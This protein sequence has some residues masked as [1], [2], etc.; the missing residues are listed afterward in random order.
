M[1]KSIFS[2]GFIILSTFILCG[3]SQAT[4]IQE[5]S[6]E[7]QKILNSQNKDELSKLFSKEL[8]EDLRIKYTKFSNNLS[9]LKWIIKP[10]KN[11]SDNRQSIEVIVKGNKKIGNHNYSLFSKQRLAI[12]TEKG[13][14]IKQ[15]I[16]SEYS[17]LNTNMQDLNLTIGIPDRVLTGSKYNID[18]IF[19][20]PLKERVIAGGLIAIMQGN[21]NNADYNLTLKPTESGGLFKIVRAPLRPGKQRWAALLAHPEGLITITKTVKIV[22]SKSELKP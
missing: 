3:I 12:S 7:L 21:T 18:L 20:N 2:S 10:S 11:L 22:S 9:D 16:V 19:Q 8:A 1:L 4:E 14:I 13:K 17:I 5:L 15:E 6:K